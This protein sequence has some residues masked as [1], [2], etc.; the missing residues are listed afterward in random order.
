[1]GTVAGCF[2]KVD[3]EQHRDRRFGAISVH[4]VAGADPFRFPWPAP[5]CSTQELRARCTPRRDADHT[6]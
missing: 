5:T 3:A 1:A 2:Q 6:A 4:V